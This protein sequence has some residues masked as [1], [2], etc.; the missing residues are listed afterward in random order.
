MK[1]DKDKY[2]VCRVKG[3]PTFPE[4]KKKETQMPDATRRMLDDEP[5][6]D[7]AASGN[8]DRLLGKMRHLLREARGLNLEI[9]RLSPDWMLADT[10]EIDRGLTFA[11]N[12]IDR[13]N[14][15]VVDARKA[16]REESN[17]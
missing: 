3:D 6:T 1:V 4:R 13:L 12:R 10:K 2:V 8:V 7:F 15:D 11:L 14:R 5:P 16:N 17:G 9:E